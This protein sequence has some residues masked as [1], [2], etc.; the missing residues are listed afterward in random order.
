MSIISGYPV[1]RPLWWVD[2]D[3]FQTYTLDSEFM[4]GNSLLVAPILEAGARHR[5]IYIPQGHWRDNLRGQTFVN[6]GTGGWIRNY[7]VDLNQIPTFEL[8]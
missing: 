2:P 1:I 5:D 4:V 6:V 8:I 3:D 7:K